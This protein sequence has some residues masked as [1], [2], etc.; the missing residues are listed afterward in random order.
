MD[1]TDQDIILNR[2]SLAV[3]RNRAHV[4][5]WL[6]PK[7]LE[8]AKAEEQESAVDLEQ[9]F[10]HLPE[11]AGLGSSVRYTDEGDSE[12]AKAGTGGRKLE[13][14]ERFL[15]VLLGRRQAKAHLANRSGGAGGKIRGPK[16]VASREKKAQ[17]GR[18]D[19]EEEEEGGR[20]AAFGSKKLRYGSHTFA[21]ESETLS[22]LENSDVG[23]GPEG[24]E[25]AR[26]GD[27]ALILPSVPQVADSRPAKRRAG[28]YLDELLSQKAKKAKKK[29]TSTHT[30]QS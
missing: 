30:Q 6:S 2:I 5:S 11:D 25:L 3:S 19:E 17:L 21:G 18:D 23:V 10:R 26:Q 8:E 14:G 4:A 29:K 22:S 1:H 13:S 27:D 16:S 9:A 7:T 20:A 24:Q 15:E 28:T 12:S